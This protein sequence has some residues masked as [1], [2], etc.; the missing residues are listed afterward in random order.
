MKYFK[1][2]YLMVGGLLLLLVGTGSIVYG[3]KHRTPNREINRSEFEQ[4]LQAN[5]IT[6]GHVTPTPYAGIYYVEGVRKSGEKTEK[7]YITT[8]L[9]EAQVKA[10][11]AQ[12]T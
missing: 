12:N 11:L 9:E 2:L 5:S 6:E 10:L 1:N 4:L 3:L 8:H 7:V